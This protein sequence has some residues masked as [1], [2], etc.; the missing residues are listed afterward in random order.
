MDMA[1]VYQTKDKDVHSMDVLDLKAKN[2]P[3]AEKLA[4]RAGSTAVA[5]H[6]PVPSAL[7]MAETARRSHKYRENQSSAQYAN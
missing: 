5:H 3:S 4:H 1:H 2:H 6:R 7:R